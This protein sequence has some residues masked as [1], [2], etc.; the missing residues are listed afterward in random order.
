VRF[1]RGF[2]DPEAENPAGMDADQRRVGSATLRSGDR[3][4]Y[5]TDLQ[6]PHPPRLRGGDVVDD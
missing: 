4:C 1:A 6:E 2:F 5:P 3:L